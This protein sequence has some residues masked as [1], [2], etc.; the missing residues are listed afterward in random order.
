ME[1]FLGEYKFVKD[2]GKAEA[3]FKAM[4]QNLLLR[5]VTVASM[6]NIVPKL[7]RCSPSADGKQRFK[8]M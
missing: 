2:D 4:G 6:P 8:A 1:R 5:K 7:E 3:V